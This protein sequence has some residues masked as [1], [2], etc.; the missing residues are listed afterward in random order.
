MAACPTRL[1]PSTKGWLW[2]SEKP[3]AAAFSTSV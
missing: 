3:S 1:L 2:I